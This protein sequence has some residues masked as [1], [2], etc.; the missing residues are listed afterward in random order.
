MVDSNEEVKWEW[1]VGD[2]G[3]NFDIPPIDRMPLPPSTMLQG[4]Y[5]SWWAENQHRW[6][7]DLRGKTLEEV[8]QEAR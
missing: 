2:Q 7:L 5:A 4:R 8:E 3:F 6:V 1:Q